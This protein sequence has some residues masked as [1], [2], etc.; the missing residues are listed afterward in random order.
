MFHLTNIRSD[1]KATGEVEVIEFLKNNPSDGIRPR[2]KEALRLAVATGL[3]LKMTHD[4]KMV[5]CS[6]IYRYERPS[7]DFIVGEIGTMRVSPVGEGYGF[8]SFF[9]SYHLLQFAADGYYGVEQQLFAVVGSGTDSEKNLK[10]RV[11]MKLWI[12]TAEI[13]HLRDEAGFPFDPDKPVLKANLSTFQLARDNLKSW[14][15]EENL[16]RTPNPKKQDVI[17]IDIRG[18]TP[19]MLD[20]KIE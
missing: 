1:E 2:S 3:P 5:G 18:F 4:N 10:D 8:Q 19:E 16:F 20:I 11:A 15:I 12:P 6:F 13:K 9:A 7:D 14:H 17:S